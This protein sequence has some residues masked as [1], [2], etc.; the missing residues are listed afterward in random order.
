MSIICN[1]CNSE[2]ISEELLQIHKRK[3]RVKKVV[4]KNNKKKDNDI[5]GKD[6][7]RVF[8]KEKNLPRIVSYCQKDVATVA[9]LV[10]R[11]KGMTLLSENQI[12]IF[13]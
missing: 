13:D 7:G 8:W 9:Q 12:E 3:I 2:F 5:E 4:K 1:H 11:F 6:V 10:M